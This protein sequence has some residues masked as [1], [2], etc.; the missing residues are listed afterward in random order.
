MHIWRT[1]GHEI[2]SSFVVGGLPILVAYWWGGVPLLNQAATSMWPG[3]YLLWYSL[4]VSVLAAAIMYA[5][6]RIKC[7]P[8]RPMDN[9]LHDI[10]GSLQGIFRLVAG[11]LLTFCVLWWFS[12]R[13]SINVNIVLFAVYGCV[14]FA[15]TVLYSLGV[16]WLD[17]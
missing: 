5:A 7:R 4:S 14:S 8:P 10:V 3:H 11:F 16:A 12:D 15:Y 6:K 2:V 1:I 13:A 17:S 9:L